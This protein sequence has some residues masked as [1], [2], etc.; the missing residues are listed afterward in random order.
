MVEL[1][2]TSMA[3]DYLLDNF[4]DEVRKGKYKK[5][6]YPTWKRLRELATKKETIIASIMFPIN[7][8]TPWILIDDLDLD[9]GNEFTK[10]FLQSYDTSSLDDY[11]ILDADSSLATALRANAEASLVTTT[12]SLYHGLSTVS[13]TAIDNFN[14][15]AYGDL[16]INR[17]YVAYDED[18]EKFIDN[19]EEENCNMKGFNFDFGPVN[20]NAVRVSMYGL[21]VQ[22]KDGVFVSY[23]K[24]TKD[25]IDVDI[26]NVNGEKFLY[27]MPVAINDVKI[28]DV[29]IHNHKPMIVLNIAV[30]NKSL[31]VVDVVEGERKDIMLTKSPFGFNFATKVVNF[32]DGAFTATSDNPFGNM[33]MMFA[34]SEDSDM[35]DI[36]PLM[37]MSNSGQGEFNPMMMALMMSKG[38]NSDLLPLMM[39]MNMPKQETHKCSCGNCNHENENGNQRCQDC[40]K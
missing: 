32:L 36:L 37:M 3:W 11:K 23:D 6:D 8:T 16:I 33:W 24:D 1:K 19:K 35:S 29:V 30:N 5:I 18:T 10:Y 39:M 22:N 20:G 38:K 27:K 9:G 26:L 13:D 12:T 21:A 28:G 2:F 7:G 25:I 40:E 31:N 4:N 34:L 14:K 17:P 15:G